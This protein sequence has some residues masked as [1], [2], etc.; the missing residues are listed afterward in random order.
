MH[1]L[2]QPSRI[3]LQVSRDRC[4]RLA[5]HLMVERYD[6]ASKI[7]HHRATAALAARRRNHDGA[8]EAFVDSLHQL[9]RPPIGHTHLAGCAGD[10]PGRID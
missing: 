7:G 8:I 5:F 3:L 4:G 10:R 6:L 9:P 1:G 2:T